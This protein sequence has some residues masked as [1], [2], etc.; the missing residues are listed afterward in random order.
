[1]THPKV[2]CQSWANHKRAKG[3]PIPRNP[4]PFPEIAGIILH[5]LAHEITQPPKL[6]TPY[7]R[8]ALIFQDHPTPQ[9]CV[10]LLRLTA[11]SVWNTETCFH[12]TM[13][14]SGF[15]S[16]AKPRT[17]LD[18]LSQELTQ[19]LGHAHHLTHFPATPSQRKRKKVVFSPSSFFLFD[20]K[21]I[22]CLVLRAEPSCL[23]ACILHK[24]PVL[25]N[26][27]LT[28]H[29]ASHWIPSVLRHKEP[30]LH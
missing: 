3:G 22:A 27:L 26:L 19:D 15:L 9:D 2:P 28:Y 8:A 16:C 5:S 12:F 13:A 14:C 10:C 11:F 25:I 23:P 17:S 24:H 18:C 20:Y 6:T 30:E 7:F 4:C 1:M 29:F 21:N